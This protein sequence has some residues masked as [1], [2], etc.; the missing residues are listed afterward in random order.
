MVL[1]NSIPPDDCIYSSFANA[2]SY[3]IRIILNRQEVVKQKMDET[4]KEKITVFA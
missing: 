1:Q 4:P 3:Y 2:F